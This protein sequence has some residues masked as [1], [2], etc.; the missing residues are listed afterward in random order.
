M[1][2][3]QILIVEDEEFSS[4]LIRDALKGLGYTVAGIASTGKEAVEKAEATRP[5]LVLMDIVLKGEMD[6]VAAAKQIRERCD[7]PVIYLSALTGDELLKR[8]EPI[9]PFEYILKPFQKRELHT[10]IEMTIYK[11]RI[12]KKLRENE[13]KFHNLID[14][15]ND[16]V[17]EVDENMVYT[18]VSRMDRNILGYKPEE[19]LGKTPFDFMPPDE[20]KR[21][22]ATLEP[23]LSQRRPFNSLE[24]ISHHK[25]GHTVVLETSGIP[26]FD[27]S[28]RFC[29]YH[30]IDKD[31]T[32][33]KRIEQELSNAISQIGKAKKEWETTFDAIRDPIC[34]HDEQFRIVRANKAY[35]EMAGMKFKE[36]LGRPYYEVLPKLD[37]PLK[38]CLKSP[39]LQEE[40][41]SSLDKIFK[42]RSYPVGD[43]TGKYP[44]FVHIMEDITEI[45]KV[46]GALRTS[47]ANLKKAQEVANIGSWYLDITKNE[48]IW[49]DETYRIFKVPAETSLTYETFIEVVHPDDREYVDKAWAA[50]LKREPYDIEHRILAGGELKWVRERAEIEFDGEGK[51]IQGTGTVQDITKRKKAEEK[52]KTEME[53]TNHLLMIAEAT[54]HTTD[55]DKLMEQVI[56]CCNKIMDSDICLSY[57]RD[58][59]RKEFR[60]YHAAGLNNATMPLFRAEILDE[61]VEFVKKALDGKVPV[62]IQLGDGNPEL[63]VK[64]KKTS[65]PSSELQ[66]P[67]YFL[68]LPHIKNIAIIPLF[69][70][71]E[72][73]G[74]IIAIYKKTRE[75]SERD[76]KIMSGISGQ[77][78]TAL[79]EARLYRESI[80]R[81]MELARRIEVI[82]TMNEI[83]RCILS[84]LDPME[85]LETASRMVS[86]V[87]PTDYVSIALVDREKRGFKYVTGLGGKVLQKPSFIVF[88][89]TSAAEILKTGRPEYVANLKE[90]PELLPTEQKLM[91]DGFLSHI[92]MPITVKGE[93]AGILTVGAKR[94]SAFTADDLSIMDKLVSQ[95]SVA[96]EN[97]RLVTN[98]Q[99]LFMGTVESLSSAIDAK[100]PWTA[101]H[102]ARVTKYALDI[103]KESGFSENEMRDLQ[104][105]GLLHDVG[106]IGTYEAILN[107]PEKLTEEELKVMRMHPVKGAEILMPIKQLK[108]II[109][110]VK[111][112]HEFYDCRGYPEGLKGTAIPLMARILSVADTVDAM[113]ADRPYRKGRPMDAIVGE[114]KRCS[115]TQFDP[116]IV[117]T[118]LKSL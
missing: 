61:K 89:Q 97:A 112:H 93:I 111:Y 43:M 55:K 4:I 114:L 85:V 86:R 11:H 116:R 106:K 96:M 115:G 118:F 78:S 65:T 98:L 107:K 41:V 72:H 2:N 18:Y 50:A 71:K 77:V 5:D 52:I 36:F 37:G 17:W 62:I 91:E 19:M 88:G 40:E 49:S 33:H 113:G 95:I 60:P 69:G 47:E 14:Y 90:I 56:L 1:T 79:E 83:D 103:G 108:Q 75:F 7:I 30:G 23:I 59:G 70:H 20:A 6:G 73:L 99:E 117:E 101:G 51:A 102:S 26:I 45:K 31:I 54:A 87:I 3:T 24:N 104:L 100:S 64:N 80:D 105:A 27:L 12:E 35:Q 46:E 94:P 25:D 63:G 42:V 74:F 76:M 15:I 66:T 34:M 22:L 67:N 84:T 10:I 92:R 53:I 28:G 32:K 29:G 48:L 38:M 8:V 9:E 13:L 81:T 16:R 21:A 39:E 82:Q 110:A 58:N 68:W 57:L 44:Y 109:P